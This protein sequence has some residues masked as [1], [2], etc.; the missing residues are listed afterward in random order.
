MTS[1]EETNLR[2]AGFL[3]LAKFLEGGRLKG[4][5]ADLEHELAAANGAEASRAAEEAGM[6]G[7]AGDGS[8]HGSG[9]DASA[10]RPP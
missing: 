4:V 6:G 7:R 3:Q 2:T 8:V 9:S 1:D 10:A 5:V